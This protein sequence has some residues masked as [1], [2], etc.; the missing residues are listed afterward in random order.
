MLRAF[1]KLSF[2]GPCPRLFPPRDPGVLA[3]PP[4]LV[5]VFAP[6]PPLSD[7]ELLL[8]LGDGEDAITV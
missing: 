6:E 8:L 2:S 4:L 7:A 3:L 5:G 1:C